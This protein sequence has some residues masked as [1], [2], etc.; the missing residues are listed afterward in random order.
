MSFNP[1]DVQVQRCMLTGS[2]GS[3]DISLRL[4]TV[5]VYE[6]IL[7]PYVAIDLEILDSGDIL[8]HNVGLDGNN[9]LDISFSQPGQEPYTGMFTLTSVEKAKNAQNLRTTQYNLSG[10]SRHMTKF[11]RI[12]KAYRDKTATSI[13]SDLIENFLSPDKPLVI[14]D[15]SKGVLGNQHMPYNINGVQ[16]HKAIRSTLGRAVSAKNIASLYT[17]FEDHKNMVVDTMDNLLERA[18]SSPVA[19]Y[20]QRPMGTNWPA[21]M[22]LQN[23]IILGMREEARVD[24]TTQVQHENQ[25]VQPFDVFGLKFD[26][27]DIGDKKKVSTYLNLAYN[28]LRPPT[29]LAKAM[30]ERAKRAGEF[31]TQALTIHVALNP[32]VTVGKGFAVETLAPAGDTDTA[33]RDKVS[34]V[35]LAT[36]VR[37]TL[38]LT[39]NR[40]QGTTTI[41]GTKGE[42]PK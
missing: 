2:G 21:D 15:P 24:L 14:G 19:T 40:M 12:Q 38:D 13:V 31:D 16:V 9:T 23:F 39:R 8:N 27:K 10:Y 41:R 32:G 25:K 28:V 30:P 1:G 34:G 11:P 3:V 4:K 7:K 33:V 29:Q 35:L 42:T 22:V 17:F 36:E 5:S 18:K 20:I 6:N 26:P 37:H